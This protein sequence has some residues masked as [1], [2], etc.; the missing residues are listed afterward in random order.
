MDRVMGPWTIFF[1]LTLASR[2]FR[3]TFLL[4]DHSGDVVP[5]MW[6][7]GD[8][9][10][11]PGTGPC[12]TVFTLDLLARVLRLVSLLGDHSADAVLEPDATS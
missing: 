8:L 4:G 11:N 7:V 2:A 6:G 5:E 9:E 1:T 3:P 10:T 12:K